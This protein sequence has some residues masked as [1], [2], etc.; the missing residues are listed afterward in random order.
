MRNNKAHYGNK[1]I[2]REKWTQALTLD[3]HVALRGEE[4]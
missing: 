2:I 1:S 4:H 3:F